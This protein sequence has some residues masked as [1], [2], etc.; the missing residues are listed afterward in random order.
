MSERKKIQYGRNPSKWI[1]SCESGKK[2]PVEGSN[3]DEE[4]LLDKIQPN[5]TYRHTNVA[6][7]IVGSGKISISDQI[8]TSLTISKVIS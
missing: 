7:E 4:H 2:S 1:S 8:I 3:H 5:G 6:E